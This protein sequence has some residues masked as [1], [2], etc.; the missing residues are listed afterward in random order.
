[1]KLVKEIKFGKAVARVTVAGFMDE[2]RLDG[3]VTSESLKTIPTVEIIAGGK[4]VETGS[5]ADVLEYNN[6]TD[7]LF[8]KAGLNPNKI[9]S[10]VGNRAITEGN[11]GQ[12]INDL[13]KEMKEEIATKLGEETED[14][15]KVQK[16]MEDKIE[17]AKNIVKQA[18]KEGTENLMTTK[19]LRDWRKRYNDMYNEGGEGYIPYR[20]SKESYENARKTLKEV[21]Q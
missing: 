15:K 18:E 17:I 14:K 6:M 12:E 21:T 3:I 13:I 10:K 20:V 9:Y 19:E 7:T 16:E 8:K 1:M 4:V 2:N 5:F 11:V